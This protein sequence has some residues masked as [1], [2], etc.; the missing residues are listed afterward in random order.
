[1]AYISGRISGTPLQRSPLVVRALLSIFFGLFTPSF[2]DSPEIGPGTLIGASGT[3]AVPTGTATPTSSSGSGSSNTSAI[4]GGVVGAIAT[5]VFAIVIFGIFYVRRRKRK[6]AERAMAED[7]I[8]ESSSIPDPDPFLTS[9]PGRTSVCIL[10]PSRCVRAYPCHLLLLLPRI[11]QTRPMTC[12]GLRCKQ[13]RGFRTSLHMWF[14]DH[15]R[16]PEAHCRCSSRQNCL[17][18]IA[19]CPLTPLN[20][21]PLPTTN[22][23]ARASRRSEESLLLFVTGNH[24]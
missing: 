20:L 9:T 10:V 14:L 5:L 24:L 2:V 7:T 12:C 15:I 18:S 22:H 17:H 21:R 13:R 1:M 23:A 19:S 8:I 16:D 3:S 11:R 6:R 4:V